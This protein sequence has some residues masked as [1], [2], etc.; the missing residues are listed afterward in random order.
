MT[1]QCLLL[2]DVYVGPGN[3]PHIWVNFRADLSTLDDIGVY[4]LGLSASSI[5]ISRGSMLLVSVCLSLCTLSTKKKANSLF[6]QVLQAAYILW[7]AS[8]LIRSKTLSK[9]PFYKG[10]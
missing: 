4:S 5:F 1:Y 7:F 8:L 9:I 10:Y 6:L 2:P 3:E